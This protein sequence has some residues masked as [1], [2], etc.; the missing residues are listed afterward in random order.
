L[1]LR[2]DGEAA[3]SG[4]KATVAFEGVAEHA[5]LLDVGDEAAVASF[6]THVMNSPLPHADIRGVGF[7]VHMRKDRLLAGVGAPYELAS[8]GDGTGLTVDYKNDLGL[9]L[10]DFR[11]NYVAPEYAL[12][13]FAP[14][15]KTLATTLSA[16]VQAVCSH[17]GWDCLSPTVHV[18]TATQHANYDEYANCGDGCSGNPFD[19]D[20]P[21]SPL[22]WGESHELGHNLQMG[23]LQIGY[24]TEDKRD[25]WSQYQSRAGENSNNI[26]PYHN[27]WRYGREVRK[28]VAPLHDGHMNLKTLFAMVQSS[29][30]KLVRTVNGIARQVV[31]DEGCSIVGDYPLDAKDVHAEAIWQDGGYAATNG[32]RMGFYLGL[33]MRLHGSTLSDGTKL[34]D[35]FD[36]FTLL[37]AEARLFLAAA[38]DDASW[39]AAR[40]ALGFGSFARTGDPTYAGVDVT[41]IPG[42][43]FL[44]VALSHLSGQDFRP[45]FDDHGVRYSALASQEVDAHIA[46]GLVKGAI[47]SALIVLDDDLPG[48]DLASLTTVAPDGVAAWPRDGFHPSTCP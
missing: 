8:H 44:L 33:P 4:D 3:P 19:A 38:R 29:R 36:V 41:A 25:D 30:A 39:T 14:P 43:D 16:D 26:F 15:G 45:Y 2:L 17:L 6:V 37:Y 31:F 7:E 9:L 48:A 47:A 10:A 32:P 5:A 35:G 13:G 24:V 11:D 20:W 12:A 27:L 22:G 23:V 28:D 40:E 34:S 42:N 46:S 1:Y 18:R 21:V